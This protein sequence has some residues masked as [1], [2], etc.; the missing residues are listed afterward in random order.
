MTI[1]N[2]NMTQQIVSTAYVTG[3]VCGI[4]R[5]RDLLAA[6]KENLMLAPH[7]W[8]FV[9]VAPTSVPHA[10]QSCGRICFGS[11]RNIP[12]SWPRQRSSLYR[13]RIESGK[14]SPCSKIFAC[15]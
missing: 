1:D 12:A 4:Q 2:P 5:P 7:W 3:E 13:H 14:S 10:G 15:L 9:A 6:A 11:D 8:H